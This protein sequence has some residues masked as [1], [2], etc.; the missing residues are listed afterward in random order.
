MT[1]LLKIEWVQKLTSPS[2]FAID[3]RACATLLYVTPV[4]TEYSYKI[5]HVTLSMSGIQSASVNTF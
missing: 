4:A 1:G 5:T 2:L 3:T